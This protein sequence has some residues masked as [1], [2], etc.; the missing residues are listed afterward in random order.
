[1]KIRK[2]FVSN[3]SSSSFTCGVC[4]ETQSGW[5]LCLSETEMISCE[6]GH[7]FCID[8]TIEPIWFNGYTEIKKNGRTEYLDKDMVWDD[9]NDI[10]TYR[11][12]RYSIL[13]QSCPICSFKDVPSY[14]LIKY[15]LRE[16]GLTREQVENRIRAKYEN[17]DSFE[18]A[19]NQ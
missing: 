13:P 8:H 4:D 6:N 7:I 15:M 18:K 19:Y 2:C 5:D 16:L 17:L 14:V 11:D 12:G 3:S 1:M 10:S 9:D